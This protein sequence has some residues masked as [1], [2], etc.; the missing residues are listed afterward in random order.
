MDANGPLVLVVEDDETARS[1][2]RRQLEQFGCR[3]VAVATSDEAMREV[4][5]T[6]LLAGVL[7]DINLT[8]GTDDKSGIVFARYVRK[9]RPGLPVAGYSGVFAE[10]RI[11]EDDLALFNLY[12]GAGNVSASEIRS[13]IE[14]FAELA[15]RY[16]EERKADV[17]AKLNSIR[18]SFKVDASGFA[19]FRRIIPDRN[20]EV[21]QV[22]SEV[23]SEPFFLMS[24]HLPP[25]L[26][27][28][29][30]ADVRLK[31][32]LLIWLREGSD[33][34]EAEV[35]GVPEL[36]SYGANIDEALVSLLELAISDF[37]DLLARSN[38]GGPLHRLAE[39]LAAVF[40]DSAALEPRHGS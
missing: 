1:L 15:E 5:N 25:H 33:I 30:G 37:R 20:L 24:G 23:R 26:V 31:V 13:A 18:D 29:H 39:F 9:Q 3:A 28:R 10:G 2:R 14:S 19:E 35:H 36:Y 32:P 17:E 27:P 34:A 38:L 8:P 22:L 7:T 11:S 21:E 12:C 16:D 4:W 40:Y 6:P